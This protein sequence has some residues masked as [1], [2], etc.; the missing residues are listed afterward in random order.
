MDLVIHQNDI[1]R[2]MAYYL[3]RMNTN[4]YSNP[5]G[6]HIIFSLIGVPGREGHIIRIAPEIWEIHT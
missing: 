2:Q 5:S 4:L 3:Q 6:S 1:L